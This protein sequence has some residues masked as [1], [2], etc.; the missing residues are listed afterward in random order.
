MKIT[1]R[2]IIVTT[3]CAVIGIFALR[4]LS[5]TVPQIAPFVP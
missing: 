3:L 2:K 4:Q 1:A 5:K